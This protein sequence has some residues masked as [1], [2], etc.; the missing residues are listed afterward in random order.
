MGIIVILL[1]AA[2]LFLL[3]VYV[4]KR[5]PGSRTVKEYLYA[6]GNISERTL[7]ISMFSMW[8]WTTS[9]L[10]ATEAGINYGLL[11]CAAYAV[12]ADLG[13]VI[14]IC[15]INTDRRRYGTTFFLTDFIGPRF[16]AVCE[17]FFFVIY[18]LMPAYT[19]VQQVVGFSNVFSTLWGLSYKIT[20]VLIVMMVAAFVIIGGMRGVLAGDVA[21]FCVIIGSLAAL[22]GI[23][24]F[25]REGEV[26]CE[27]FSLMTEDLC[28]NLQPSVMYPF[29]RGLVSYIVVMAILG[30]SETVLD[31]TFYVKA[32]LTKDE[33]QMK[34][35]FIRGG[36]C[37]WTP[38]VIFTATVLS[39]MWRALMGTQQLES[40]NTN[41]LTD[42]LFVRSRSLGLKIVFSV[43]IAAVV[44]TTIANAFM[45]IL[46]LMA[47]RG[48]EKITGEA[49]DEP[50]RINFGILFLLM[51]A[52]FCG[53][54]AL[55]LD[56]ISLFVI[57][58]VCG[59]FFAAPCGVVLFFRRGGGEDAGY[60]PVFSA[61][62]GIVAGI[63]VWMRMDSSRYSLLFGTMIAFMVPYLMNAVGKLRGKR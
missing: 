10:G 26:F 34:R 39:S 21:Y 16:S 40:M 5:F 61:I 46:T 33:E 30:A 8:M 52:L 38:V 43:V 44:I 62:V 12:G 20:A 27:G 31:P 24:I 14:M 11:G 53:L 47:L 57:N 23:F 63:F 3:A 19:V 13:F 54:I 9:I 7:V 55:S 28:R 59:I 49:G 41:L 35:V 6:G 42:I 18:V 58:I 15:T 48:H 45:S 4:R 22:L 56:N 60:F 36:I 51:L 2:V 17:K 25:G 32:N 37:I 1:Q 29:L 50:A